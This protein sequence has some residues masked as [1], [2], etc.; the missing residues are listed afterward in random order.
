MN[1][2]EHTGATALN[3]LIKSHLSQVDHRR[4]FSPHPHHL[5]YISCRSSPHYMCRS[6]C[7]GAVRHST[8]NLAQLTPRDF[9]SRH[10]GNRPS[11]K[12][13]A[14]HFFDFLVSVRST[15][16]VEE[17]LHSGARI[18]PTGTRR[19]RGDLVGDYGSRMRSSGA[20]CAPCQH[21]IG[22][23][24]LVRVRVGVRVRVRV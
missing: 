16:Y 2:V 22:R 24:R 4:L 17:A 1:I 14:P 18:C 6:Q 21:T 20:G 7:H 11:S 9:G 23:R 13:T 19:L 10:T 15:C 5:R 12:S 3:T 8:R